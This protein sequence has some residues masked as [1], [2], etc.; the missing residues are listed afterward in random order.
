ML[1]YILSL[2]YVNQTMTH[3]LTWGAYAELYITPVKDLEWYF[4]M[5]VNGD[6]VKDTGDLAGLSPV[7][8]A[9]STGITWYLPA[10]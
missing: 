4:E 3:A 7:S 5:D 9:A 6:V 8:F 10:L 1:V 2:L